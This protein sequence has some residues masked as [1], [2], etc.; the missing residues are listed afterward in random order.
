M[1]AVY[2]NRNEDIYCRDSRHSSKMLSYH[3]HLHYQIEMAVVFEGHTHLTVD[4]AEYEVHSGDIL[5]VFPNQIHE[6]RTIDRERFVLLKINPEVM[7]ELLGQFTSS[8]PRCNV[9][10]GAARD[11]ELSRLIVQISDTYYGK[12]PMREIVL[13]GYLLAFF[14]KLLQKL[15]LRDASSGDYH[16][17]GLIMNYC[18]CNFDKELSLSVLEKEL[19][20]NKYYISH[21][22][23]NKLHIGLNGYVN[24]LRVSNACRQLLKTDRTVTEISNRV[25]FNTLRTFN[26]AFMKQ[27]GMTP[28]EYRRN[29]RTGGKSV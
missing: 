5:I 26:R 2:E 21:M 6:F 24:S 19:H 23:N 22:M 27:M 28:S 17:L 7:P 16:A 4:S 14:G 10:K 1:Q 9:A 18:N 11:E 20:L 15:E 25:G 3:S 12:E 8:L 29:K 13:R